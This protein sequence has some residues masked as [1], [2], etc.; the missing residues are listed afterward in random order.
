MSEGQLKIGAIHTYIELY[1][2]LHVDL[3][4]NVPVP[5]F[6]ADRAGNLYTGPSI[7]ATPALVEVAAFRNGIGI[8]QVK[9]STT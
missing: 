9:S 5:G 4:P 1:A 6:K 7:E 2:R 8:A 3:T